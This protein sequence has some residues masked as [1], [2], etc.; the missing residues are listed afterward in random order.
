MATG[1]FKTKHSVNFVRKDD[2][3]VTATIDVGQ[4]KIPDY[5]FIYGQY[6]L[7]GYSGLRYTYIKFP[8]EATVNLYYYAADNLRYD[9]TI[10]TFS[11]SGTKLTININDQPLG[12][13]RFYGTYNIYY[14]Y[15]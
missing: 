3:T 8:G 13:Y 7:G 10:V 2:Y 4:N 11:L 9:A 1:Q 14:A 12:Q 5:L 15:S 6:P